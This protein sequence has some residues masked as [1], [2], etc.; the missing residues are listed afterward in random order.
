MAAAEVPLPPPAV[1]LVVEEDRSA[2]P[3]ATIQNWVEGE[4]A[5]RGRVRGRRR[6]HRR[7]LYDGAWSTSLRWGR[8]GM[9]PVKARDARGLTI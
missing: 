1:R 3:W 6:L 7:R 5:D 4:K 9:L 2:I 8:E